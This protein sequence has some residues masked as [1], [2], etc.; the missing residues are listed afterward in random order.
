MAA[1]PPA[2][3]SVEV[4]A[5]PVC[6]EDKLYVYTGNFDNDDKLVETV[7]DMEPRLQRFQ[8]AALQ[9]HTAPASSVSS[10]DD[11]Q[12]AVAFSIPAIA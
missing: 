12:R 3:N 1:K 7:I 8:L 6:L 4:E 9:K 5:E 11:I 10:D 2:I